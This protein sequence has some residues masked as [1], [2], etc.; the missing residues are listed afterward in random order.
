MDKQNGMYYRRYKVVRN[1]YTNSI[2]DLADEEQNNLPPEPV[3][4]IVTFNVQGHGTAPSSQEVIAGEKATEPSEP[5]AQD[6]AFGGWY[7][8]ASCTN[9]WD[10]S[11]DTVNADTTLYAKWILTRVTDLT[12]TTWT[13]N[14]TLSLFSGRQINLSFECDSDAYTNMSSVWQTLEKRLLN[15]F[16]NSSINVYDSGEGGWSDEK[17]KTV[18]ITG[19]TS[20]NLDDTQNSEIIDWFYDNA[21]LI[22]N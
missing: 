9:A 6:Y 20:Q 14:D 11:V 1:T 5:T 21:T 16:S 4:Y 8:E 10:F 3:A 19:P 22:Y 15:Y 18:H 7:K 12:N 13:F 2:S 17:Y